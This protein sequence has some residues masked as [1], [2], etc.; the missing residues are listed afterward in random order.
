MAEAAATSMALTTLPYRTGV[1]CGGGGDNSPR[2]RDGPAEA[3]LPPAPCCCIGGGVGSRATCRGVGD[4]SRGWPTTARCGF[5]VGGADGSDGEVGSVGLLA[6]VRVV[7]VGT[8]VVLV[9]AEGVV[10]AVARALS[11][12]ARHRRFTLDAG[13]SNAVAVVVYS[14]AGEVVSAVRR[15]GGCVSVSWWVGLVT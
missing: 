9:G 3:G 14:A 10:V 1:C 2:R 8:V 6:V 11:E 13:W 5:G 7:R 15:R 4:I 12:V